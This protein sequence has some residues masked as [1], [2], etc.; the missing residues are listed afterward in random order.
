MGECMLGRNG[1]DGFQSCEGFDEWSTFSSADWTEPQQT[2]DLGGFQDKARK[3][4]SSAIPVKETGTFEFPENA[5]NGDKVNPWFIFN[6]CFQVEEAEENL[7]MVEIPTLSQLQQTILDMPCQP[8]AIS[9]Q[10]AHFWCNLQS[11]STFLR[12]SGP[13]PK[14]YSHEGLLKTL[15][16]RHPDTSAD[17]QTINL[18]DLELENPEDPPGAL[19]Q[20]KVCVFKELS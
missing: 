15:Q 14:L 7:I 9:S 6:D 13:K 4:K 5:E 12:L 2:S 3:A 11:G 18:S 17:S 8:A 10:A 1:E 19:I 20:T 16:L